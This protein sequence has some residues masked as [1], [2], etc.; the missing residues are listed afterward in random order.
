MATPLTLR[1]NGR[2]ASADTDAQTPL[3]YLLGAEEE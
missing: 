3:L 2:T 1:L